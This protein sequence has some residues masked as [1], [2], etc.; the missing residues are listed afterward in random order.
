VSSTNVG[1]SDDGQLLVT[2]E[3]RNRGDGRATRSVVVEVTVDDETVSASTDVSVPGGG[4]AEFSVV[5]PVEYGRFNDGGTLD[6]T[7]A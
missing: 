7:L 6:V 1:E 5:V 2:G 3:V 4:T